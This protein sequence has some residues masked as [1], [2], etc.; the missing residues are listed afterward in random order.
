MISGSFRRANGEIRLQGGSEAGNSLPPIVVRDRSR[1]LELLSQA[2]QKD[3][4]SI[5]PPLGGDMLGHP[6]L[7][8]VGCA[9]GYFE[10]LIGLL[11]TVRIDSISMSEQVTM[12]LC[13]GQAQVSHRHTQPHFAALADAGVEFSDQRLPRVTH[14][15]A[16]HSQD[17]RSFP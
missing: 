15:I 4:G 11:A 17:T 13:T 3:E 8:G 1:C 5:A 9:P 2:S 14:C 7:G 12:Q 6:T 16:G 10:G